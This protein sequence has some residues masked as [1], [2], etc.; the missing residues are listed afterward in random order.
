MQMDY[1]HPD[2][3][4]IISSPPRS[5]PAAVLTFDAVG[6]TQFDHDGCPVPFILLHYGGQRDIMAVC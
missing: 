4:T 2:L 5:S 1:L 3:Q 6:G